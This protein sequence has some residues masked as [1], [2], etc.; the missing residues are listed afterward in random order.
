MSVREKRVRHVNAV[1]T[2][3]CRLSVG[4]H[5]RS[6]QDRVRRA[7]ITQAVPR[8]QGWLSLT[9]RYFDALRGSAGKATDR[10]GRVRRGGRLRL[11]RKAARSQASC[12]CCAHTRSCLL[13]RCRLSLR[14]RCLVACA[15]EILRF[16]QEAAHMPR[17]HVTRSFMGPL[18]R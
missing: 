10:T 18:A 12:A 17:A 2:G 6:Q 13:L 14:A 8:A 1:H 5:T 4:I 16:F 7:R 9:C 11:A 15:R 3:S